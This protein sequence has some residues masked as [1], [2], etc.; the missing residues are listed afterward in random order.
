[1]L[2]RDQR[3]S[4]LSSAVKISANHGLNLIREELYTD[5]RLNDILCERYQVHMGQWGRKVLKRHDKVLT[6]SSDIGMFLSGFADKRDTH[7]RMS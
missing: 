3:V 7:I 1:M 2:C 5:V 4:S 6:A